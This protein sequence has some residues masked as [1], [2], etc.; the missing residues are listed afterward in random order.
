MLPPLVAL[1]A[2]RRRRRPAD[3]LLRPVARRGVPAAARRHVGERVRLRP[4]ALQGDDAHLH[5]T[6]RRARTARRAVQH[7]RRE[8]ARGG[9]I[10]RGA[11]RAACCRRGSRRCS[12]L[13][14]YIL[15]A[16]LGGGAVGAVPGV[17]KARFGAHEVIVTIMLNFIVLALLNYLTST[18][19]ARARHAAHGG[20]PERTR[21]RG[22]PI[23]RPPSRA[24]RRTS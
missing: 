9:R 20:D 15:A 19:A 22:S 6:R 11:R 21:C 12:C 13:P 1:L 5:R 3:P 2:R 7:R 16:A 10:L 18:Q 14:V 8:P 4:G 23:C 17:L 24:R